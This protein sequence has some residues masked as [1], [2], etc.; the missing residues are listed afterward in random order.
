VFGSDHS[1]RRFNPALTGNS[2]SFAVDGH[3]EVYFE[4][5]AVIL[6][7]TL[8]GQ[9]L[10]LKARSKTSAAIKSLLGL[11]PKTARRVN[12]DG[13][14][15]E[16]PLADVHVGDL[17]RVRPGEK[18]PVDGVVI[19]GGSAVDESMLTGEPMPVAKKVGDKLIGATLNQRRARD[20]LGE[21]RRRNRA[22]GHRTDDGPGAA[23]A[24]ADAAHG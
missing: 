16:L 7:L 13:T 10:E 3:V 11:A 17:L 9:M 4:A 23:L 18:V 1:T 14:E 22:G 15:Q 8:L 20:A 5:S 21:G 19:E 6:S 24:C 2:P 12:A